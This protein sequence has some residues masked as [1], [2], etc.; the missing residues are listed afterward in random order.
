[1]S[2]F[3]ILKENEMCSLQCTLLKVSIISKKLLLRSTEGLV[4]FAPL[5]RIITKCWLATEASLT[6]E[7]GLFSYRTR[8]IYQH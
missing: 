6:H 5:V 7:N 2:V 3:S 8:H 4:R 1:M